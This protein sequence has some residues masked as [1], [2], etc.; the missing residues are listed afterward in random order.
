MKPQKARPIRIA[1]ST[2]NTHISILTDT[3]NA[4]SDTNA[5]LGYLIVVGELIDAKRKLELSLLDAN[6]VEREGCK[7]D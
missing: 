7:D 6:K 4:T 5:H 3:I 2:I 1:L